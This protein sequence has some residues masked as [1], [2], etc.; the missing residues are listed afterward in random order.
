MTP[1]DVIGWMV[2]VV[3]VGF[4]LVAVVAAVMG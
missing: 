1:G 4:G 2:F 3:V